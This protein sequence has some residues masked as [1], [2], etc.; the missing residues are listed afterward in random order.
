M[1]EETLNFNWLNNWLTQVTYT[2]LLLTEGTDIQGLEAKCATMME[3]Y[4]PER[5]GNYRLYVQPLRDI[6]LGSSPLL[7]TAQPGTGQWIVC[8]LVHS[9]RGVGTAY[10]LYQLHEFNDSPT[11][12]PNERSGRKKSVRCT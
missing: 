12:P 6:Y 2:Y 8:A 10:R 3:E 7:Y 11:C 1:G 4:L 9:Y 5:A